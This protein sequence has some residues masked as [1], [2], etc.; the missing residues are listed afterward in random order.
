MVQELSKYISS[1]DA[2]KHLIPF[3]IQ[4]NYWSFI[5]SLNLNINLSY[6]YNNI[7]L[8]NILDDYISKGPSYR[9]SKENLLLQGTEILLDNMVDPN[10]ICYDGY[11]S[12]HF[13]VYHKDINLVQAIIRG[14]GDV[15]ICTEKGETPIGISLTHNAT[16]I[17]ALIANNKYYVP[18]KLSGLDNLITR[19]VHSTYFTN[20]LN[21]LKT[22][23][24]ENNLTISSNT[25]T[26]FPYQT[27][28]AK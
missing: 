5:P 2:D 13:V 21:I 28:Y 19:E 16:N 27:K 10:T 12:L 24:D 22:Y 4:Q 9:L 15:N 7:T 17:T 11:T 20:F 26:Y 6:I 18:P 8:C 25:I 14:G 23:V 3:I 1:K